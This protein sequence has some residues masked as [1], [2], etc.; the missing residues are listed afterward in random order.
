M[1]KNPAL[2]RAATKRALCALLLLCA[3]I[4]TFRTAWIVS[5][6]L[7]DSDASSNMILGNKLA[8]EGG[9][10][11]SSWYYSTEVQVLDSQIIFKLLF[12][13]SSDWSLVRFLGAVVMQCLMLGAYAFL[14]R[15]VRMS[16]NAF[17]V[18]GAV[19]LLPLSVP[20]G[21]TVLY[22]NYYTMVITLD[23][24]IVGL[25]LGLSRKREEK[26]ALWKT[27]AQAACLALLSFAAGLSGMRQMMTCA[28]PLLTASLLNA[29]LSERGADEKGGNRLREALPSLLWAGAALA[30][31]G[32][33]Y[34]LNSTVISDRYPFQHYDNQTL[35]FQ[36]SEGV[37]EVLR[38]LL[39]ALGLQP[40]HPLLELHG[41]LSVSSLVALL[42]AVLLAFHT[43]R[44]SEDAPTRF[45]QLFMLLSLTVMTC[46][47]IFLANGGFLY[48]IYYLPAIV[49]ILP[50]LATADARTPEALPALKRA[51]GKGGRKAPFWTA[52]R[53]RRMLGEGSRKLSA[54]G[55]VSLLACVMMLG[56]GFYHLAFFRNPEA[57]IQE[58]DYT[59]LNY[60]DPFTVSTLQPIAEKLLAEGCTLCYADYWDAAVLT[61]LTDGK[62]RTTP[63]KVGTSRR[64][65]R[66]HN[67]LADQNLRDPE[68]I[69][70]QKICIL[71]NYDLNS[72]I[73]GNEKVEPIVRHLADFGGYTLYEVTDN[74][75]M[76][77]LLD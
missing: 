26:R 42:I 7:L 25:Y 50:T 10:F 39:S 61:E 2:T 23:F 59:G 32:L 49:W 51:A 62:V 43:L 27:I 29:V 41:L 38:G 73:D 55:L 46:I 13:L 33:G 22:H 76:A 63:L 15:Q 3:L 8:R 48:E 53:V 12:L 19:L 20:Y 45:I 17:C 16:F 60:H 58:I 47:F 70:Q 72:S 36:S 30:A 69:S 57:H 65:L 21:R 4:L 31:L 9:I 1:L 74:A 14:G 64:P 67:W 5:T 52:E 56:N 35:S 28:A 68:F 77:E 34:L 75:A 11:S 54:H 24:L 66:Y 71:A 6:T 40:D 18:T 37:L 44:H